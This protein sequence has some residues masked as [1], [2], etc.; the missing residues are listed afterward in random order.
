MP[1]QLHALA[2]VGSLLWAGCAH[3]PGRAAGQPEQPTAYNFELVN[4]IETTLL[5]VDGTEYA[6]LD[7]PT[8]LHWRGSL[9][10]APVRRFRDGSQGDR[11]RFGGVTMSEAGRPAQPSELSGL[12]VEL[13]GFE[14]REI[15]AIDLLEHLV[16]QPRSADLMLALWPALSPRIPT[17]E[18]GQTVRERSNLPFMLDNG[19]GTP[20]ALELDWTLDGPV[21]CAAGSCWRLS[22]TGP[23]RSR[24]L[25]RSELWYAR[26]R[27]SG[28]ARGELLMTTQDNA[29]VRSELELEIEL[30][31][32]LSD[33]ATQLPRGVILQVQHQHA[34][35]ERLAGAP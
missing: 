5:D 14:N 7:A 22:C 13:R 12:S 25:D 11:V 10:Q 6:Q 32:T 20:L 24:G 15:L 35:L 29:I 2:L 30:T 28:Q 16:G 19:M 4:I 1:S 9:E 23:V 26:Y 3:R 33:P 18:P 21:S 31:T 8:K 27:I 17:L 34:T